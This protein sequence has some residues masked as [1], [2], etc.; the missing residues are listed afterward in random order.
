[1]NKTR[2]LESDK[3]F[4]VDEAKPPPRKRLKKSSPQIQL[5]DKLCCGNSKHKS[6]KSNQNKENQEKVEQKMSQ[7]VTTAVS[8]KITNP[9]NMGSDCDDSTVITG[10]NLDDANSNDGNNMNQNLTNDI[11]KIQT[12]LYVARRTSKQM[13]EIIETIHN[14]NRKSKEFLTLLQETRAKC[15]NLAIRQASLDI[16]INFGAIARKWRKIKYHYDL[17]LLLTFDQ[18][19]RWND[20]LDQFIATSPH[21]EDVAEW[22]AIESNKE[23][24]NVMDQLR[25]VINILEKHKQQ[26]Q[27]VLS[28][29]SNDNENISKRKVTNED[30]IYILS[31]IDELKS[32]FTFNST[33]FVRANKDVITQ[34]NNS[35]NNS[36]NN[37]NEN[38]SQSSEKNSNKN[39]NSKA[40]K[41]KNSSKKQ[42]KAKPGK[43]ATVGSIKSILPDPTAQVI[44]KDKKL[45]SCSSCDQEFKDAQKARE[46]V[47]VHHAFLVQYG[48][49]GELTPYKH[50]KYKLH[51]C[52]RLVESFRKSFE[53]ID[54]GNYHFRC[55]KCN[56]LLEDE[57]AVVYHLEDVRD[58]DIAEFEWHKQNL[59]DYETQERE[60]HLSNASNQN[61]IN[62]HNNSSSDGNETDKNENNS[63]ENNNDNDN[64]NNNNNNNMNEIESKTENNGSSGSDNSG[65]G[66]EIKKNNENENNK[67]EKN[68]KFN[69]FNYGTCLTNIKIKLKNNKTKF[70]KNNIQYITAKLRDDVV[71]LPNTL[72]VK[73][74]VEEAFIGSPMENRVREA[75]NSK[76]GTNINGYQIKFEQIKHDLSSDHEVKILPQQKNVVTCNVNDEKTNENIVN[77]ENCFMDSTMANSFAQGATSQ[78]FP[79]KHIRGCWQHD[80]VLKSMHLQR[81]MFDTEGNVLENDFLQTIVNEITHLYRA[82][83]L[84][85]GW[86]NDDSTRIKN[87]FAPIL[88]GV[89]FTQK[90]LLLYLKHHKL[91]ID[92]YLKKFTPLLKDHHVIVYRILLSKLMNAID[93]AHDMNLI[94]RDIKPDNIKL[95]YYDLDP[96]GCKKFSLKERYQFALI[97]LDFGSS[98][99][100][101]GCYTPGGTPKYAAPEEIDSAK[102]CCKQ[103][104]FWSFGI[105]VKELCDNLKD[106][107]DKLKKAIEKAQVIQTLTTIQSLLLK[108]KPDDREWDKAKKLIQSM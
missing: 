45:F 75:I 15:Q 77:L 59:R 66:Y 51:R 19:W 86:Y 48:C 85:L 58:I 74:G 69:L 9:N 17:L 94:H 16:F 106:G 88:Y 105:I 96:N 38:G 95:D 42:N 81:M 70:E 89:Q 99:E 103:S 8:T 101:G 100:M 72:D 41:S 93:K 3:S 12:C 97:L 65:N 35:N 98:C 5:E 76:Y 31:Q 20:N 33:K 80:L 1:M 90:H 79:V 10:T 57:T 91:S 6:S 60:K 52:E 108:Q 23:I 7:P 47:C 50:Y 92:S 2:S 4:S 54:C 104:D 55:I 56:Q 83:C 44:R 40:K 28:T 37:G 84:M 62:K 22:D 68:I 18:V 87:D 61:N 13:L 24:G 49:C 32:R 36:N 43:K 67:N 82:T 25:G 73:K 107:S 11:H 29:V 46:H 30:V 27:Q 14:N 71:T 63:N 102:K 78:V 64:N 39:S 26:L 21:H 34:N 53:P